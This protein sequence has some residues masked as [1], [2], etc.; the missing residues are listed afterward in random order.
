M[1]SNACDKN[2]RKAMVCQPGRGSFLMGKCF[3]S[4]RE[5]YDT[6]HPLTETE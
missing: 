2:Q 5:K 6:E 3:R 4:N 1:F